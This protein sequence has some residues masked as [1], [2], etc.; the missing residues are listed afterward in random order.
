M[1]SFAR[2]TLRQVPWGLWQSEETKKRAKSLQ[3][4]VM[5]LTAQE[6]AGLR[7]EYE[8]G[9]LAAII[10]EQRASGVALMGRVAQAFS[11]EAQADNT[12]HL[13]WR[14]L[15]AIHQ[16]DAVLSAESFVLLRDAGRYLKA[17]D[18]QGGGVE[19]VVLPALD[20]LR[21]ALTSLLIELDA[22]PSEKSE[23]WDRLLDDLDQ[24]SEVADLR[25]GF[26]GV[27]DYGVE[28]GW[29]DVIEICGAQ[30]NLLDRLLDETLVIDLEYY[31]V[32][33]DAKLLLREL[34]AP[35]AGDGSSKPSQ[36][37]DLSYERVI[38]RADV[39]ASGG[40][41]D[42]AAV[43]GPQAMAATVQLAAVLDVLPSLLAGVREEVAGDAADSS[44]DDSL[45]T[46]GQAIQELQQKLPD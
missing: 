43:D 24:T 6:I 26:Q 46:L 44:L 7:Q 23:R 27:Y 31:E 18:Q 40:E 5:H 30:N 19:Q 32:F 3:G 35:Q 37:D 12:W 33:S 39:M 11:R 15:D 34:S 1:Q 16:G 8:R 22:Q 21:A 42:L 28:L 41:F 13:L 17:R 29:A 14:W 2:Y 36:I 10:D 9:L 25:R 20:T 4:T 45:E 38:E